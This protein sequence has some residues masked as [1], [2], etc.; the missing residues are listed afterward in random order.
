MLLTGE[1]DLHAARAIAAELPGLVAD[2]RQVDG[3]A[4]PGWAVAWPLEPSD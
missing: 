4:S 2:V 3:L 1:D